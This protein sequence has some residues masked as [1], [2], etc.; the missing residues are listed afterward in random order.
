MIHNLNQPLKSNN[1]VSN[2]L[3]SNDNQTAI[4]FSIINNEIVKMPKEES[5]VHAFLPTEDTNGFGVLINGN[6]STDPFEKTFNI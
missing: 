6:F 1:E 2:W 4:A 3:I 5:L